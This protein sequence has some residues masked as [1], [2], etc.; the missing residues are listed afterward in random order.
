MNYEKW[1][2]YVAEGQGNAI[3]YDDVRKE[4]DAIF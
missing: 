3:S 1:K 4:Y 2:E